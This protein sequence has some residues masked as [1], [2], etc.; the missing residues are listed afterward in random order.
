M[1]AFYLPLSSQHV[2][3]LHTV[4][5]PQRALTRGLVLVEQ[6]VAF[7][8]NLRPDTP[9]DRDVRITGAPSRLRHL[10][11]ESPEEGDTRREPL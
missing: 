4:L 11:A 5:P 1:L 8:A 2:Q 6:T 3:C 10:P 9:R 7:R